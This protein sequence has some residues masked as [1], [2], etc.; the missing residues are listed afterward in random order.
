[1]YLSTVLFHISIE[2]FYPKKNDSIIKYEG[3]KEKDP[4]KRPVDNKLK[5]KILSDQ[6]DF[7]GAHRAGG[8]AQFAAV[9]LFGIEQNFL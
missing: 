7:H 8:N 5:E 9:A 2:R 6:I 1:M 4:M 3:N